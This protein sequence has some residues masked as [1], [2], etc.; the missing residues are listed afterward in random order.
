MT[1]RDELRRV[2][3]SDGRVLVGASFRGVP[4]FVDESTRGGGRRLV[5]HEFPYRDDNYVNDLGRRTRTFQVQG[6]VIGADYVAQRDALLAALEDTAGPGELVHPYHGVRRALCGPCSVHETTRDGGMGTFSMEFTEAPA[7][8]VVANIELSMEAEVKAAAVAAATAADTEFQA[9]YSCTDVAAAR[10]AS[11]EVLIERMAT[12]LGEELKPIV[13]F[14]QE[15]AGLNRQVAALIDEA[16]TLART[17]ADVL[18]TFLGAITDLADT[19]AGSPEE[20]WRGLVNAYGAD[21]EG[22]VAAINAVTPSGEQELEN[23]EALGTGL[24]R[25]LLTEAA[26]LI[27]EI[28]FETFEEAIAAREELAAL[29]DEQAAVAT[30]DAYPAL[31]E[32]RAAVCRAVPGDADLARVITVTR[33]VAIPSLLVAY[34]LYGSVDYEADILARNEVSHPGFLSGELY[35]LS[36]V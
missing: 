36:D 12:K 8:N 26:K 22:I 7:Q 5:N 18:S 11:A 29:L 17:P 6:Y 3:L 34:Q 32:L 15:L 21:V 33:P 31:V 25:A 10:L 9:R 19:I 4:F 23:A 16:S 24:R 2:T 35:V 28:E 13:Q 30:D 14:T 20:M 27:V 1:W